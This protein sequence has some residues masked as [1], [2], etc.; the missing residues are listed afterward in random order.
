MRETSSR[1]AAQTFI[2]SQS[3]L[4]FPIYGDLYGGLFT[5]IGNLWK[6]SEG[7]RSSAS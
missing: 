5:D 1:T 2:A 4:R 7:A 3:E 6:R